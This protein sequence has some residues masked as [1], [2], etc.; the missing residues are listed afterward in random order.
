M[1]RTG[2][3]EQAAGEGAPGGF[4]STSVFSQSSGCYRQESPQHQTCREVGSLGAPRA[5][6]AT[7]C[8]G[9]GC[10]E[11]RDPQ[12]MIEDLQSLGY[13]NSSL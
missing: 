7:L 6:P 10:M 4:G 11:L 9:S 5:I 12:S 3:S 2:D 8:P 13:P 1:K